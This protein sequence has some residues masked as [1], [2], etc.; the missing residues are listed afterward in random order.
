M[1]AKVPKTLLTQAND[2]AKQLRRQLMRGAV[3]VFVTAGLPG[4][5]RGTRSTARMFGAVVQAFDM[6]D[7]W[8]ERCRAGASTL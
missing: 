4:K 6:N 3:V 7:Q 5:K 1:L 8:C 2:S